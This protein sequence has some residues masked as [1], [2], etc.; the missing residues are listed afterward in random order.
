MSMVVYKSGE[1]NI[2]FEIPFLVGMVERPNTNPK[3]SMSYLKP[4]SLTESSNL[5]LISK[6]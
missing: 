2:K 1:E 3:L 5:L 6:C 4:V